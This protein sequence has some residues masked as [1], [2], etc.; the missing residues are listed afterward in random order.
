VRPLFKQDI[1]VQGC[2]LM[3]ML[4]ALVAN[5]DQF[6]ALE[7]ALKGHGP[8]ARGVWCSAQALYNRRIRAD[9]GAG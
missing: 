2:K 4:T 3:D 1:P 9:L 8:T 6:K 7:P 5:L